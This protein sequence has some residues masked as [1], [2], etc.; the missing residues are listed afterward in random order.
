MPGTDDGRGYLLPVDADPNTAEED[1]Y[2]VDLLYRNVGG[3]AEA[4]SVRVYLDAC[5]SGGSHDGRSLIR[6]ASPVYVAATLPEEVTGKVTALAAASGEQVA[7]WDEAVRHGLFTHHLLD[8]LYG[9][10]DANGDGHVTAAEAKRYLDRH[11]TRAA[12]RQHR[13]IQQANLV[14]AEGAV[15]T[16]TGDG[17]EYPRRPELEGP[18]SAAST[19][20]EA[21]QEPPAGSTAAAGETAVPAA[22]AEQVEAALA[23]TYP[24]RVQVQHG[25]AALGF[26]TGMADGVFGR[27]TRTAI[28]DYQRRKGLPETGYLTAELRDALVAMGEE[29]QA[30]ERREDTEHLS[31]PQ[32]EGTQPADETPTSREPE[33]VSD[34]PKKWSVSAP[35]IDGDLVPDILAGFYGDGRSDRYENFRIRGASDGRVIAWVSGRVPMVT[36]ADLDGDGDIDVLCPVDVE[37]DHAGDRIVW[38]ENQGG[39]VFSGERVITTDVERPNFVFAADLDGDG[40]QDVLSASPED[41]KVAW[42]Q[43]SGGGAFSGQRTL[44]TDNHGPVSVFAADLDGDGDLEVLYGSVATNEIKW[45]ENLGSGRFSEA[46]A[47]AAP[48][49][50]KAWAIVFAFDWDRDSDADVFLY[51]ALT[52]AMYFYENL[53]GGTISGS[54]LLVSED[55]SFKFR[56]FLADMDGDGNPDLIYSATDGTVRWQAS[57]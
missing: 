55:Y 36:A 4:R 33:V 41:R 7:S 37:D 57:D 38:F 2:P 15:L 51:S 27:R 19:S 13:R 14:G 24:E 52:D 21:S 20:A 53:G 43:N 3:L 1:G 9:G 12:R 11:M 47:I 56:A 50:Q 40:A 22:T 48:D 8:A 31:A 39:G 25:L 16:S 18:G 35:D 32:Q 26:E 17:G 34:P 5:F 49:G 28:A 30:A 44:A 6:N 23:L 54:P 42:Y 10:G 45:Y 29:K 46:R